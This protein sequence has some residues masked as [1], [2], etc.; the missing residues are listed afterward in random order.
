[1]KS[2]I[3]RVILGPTCLVGIRIGEVQFVS[4]KLFYLKTAG[5][6]EPFTRFNYS[7]MT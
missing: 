3:G 2:V 7:S 5:I 1:M 4:F 6:V